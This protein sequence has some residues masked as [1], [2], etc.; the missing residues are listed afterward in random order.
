[1]ALLLHPDKN[2]EES[3]ALAFKRVN[4]AWGV[5][6]AALS[7][8]EYDATL[9]EGGDV[10]TGEVEQEE[11]AAAPAAAPAVPPKVAGRRRAARAR[12]G[13]AR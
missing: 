13:R 12:P 8:A 3:A 10:E 5:V 9:D 4:D 6:G 7:R 1:M 11:A 2:P